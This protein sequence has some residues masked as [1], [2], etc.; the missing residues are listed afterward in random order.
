MECVSLSG[1]CMVRVKLTMVAEAASLAV[2]DSNILHTDNT[3]LNNARICAVLTIHGQ[4]LG[5]I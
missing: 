4:N 3:M 2:L 1:S 5:F